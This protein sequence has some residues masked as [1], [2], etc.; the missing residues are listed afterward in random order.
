MNERFTTLA[1]ISE[2][3]MEHALMSDVGMKSI[4]DD[5]ELFGASSWATSEEVTGIKIQVQHVEDQESDDW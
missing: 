4:L 5:F 1:I 3:E 2:N